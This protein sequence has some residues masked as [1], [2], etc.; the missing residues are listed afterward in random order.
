[1]FDFT[2]SITPQ[3]GGDALE[4]NFSDIKKGKVV[5]RARELSKGRFL[6]ECPTLLFVRLRH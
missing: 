3:G 4:I 5:P 2:H 1:M 6:E